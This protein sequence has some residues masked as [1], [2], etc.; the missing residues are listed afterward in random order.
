MAKSFQQAQYRWELRPILDLNPSYGMYINIPFCRSFCSFCPFYKTRYQKDTVDKYVDALLEEIRYQPLPGSPAWVYMGGGTPN[1]LNLKQLHSIVDG[2]SSRVDFSEAG[3]E[4]MPKLADDNYLEALKAMGFRKISMG[5]ESFNQSVNQRVRRTA[6]DQTRIQKLF[7]K[8]RSLG[9][10]TNLDL[11]VGLQSQDADIF[12]SDLKIAT[13]LQPDQVTIYPFMV[14]RGFQVEPGIPE[15]Q[16]FDLIEKA[17]DLLHPQGFRRLGPWTFSQA[18]GEYDCSKAELVSDYIGFG[19]GSFSTNKRWKVV[20]P[21]VDYYI[22]WM[23]VPGRKALI[24]EKSPE[25]DQWRQFGWMLSEMEVRNR[26][27]LSRAINLYIRWL[28]LTGYLRKGKLTR[29]GI[30]L[31][32]HLMKT[33][34]E[35]LPFPIQDTQKIL[36][37]DTYYQEIGKVEEWWKATAQTAS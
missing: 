25:A 17:W 26:S 1:T 30:L 31:S 5:V 34:V 33:I 36:N 20:N 18:D 9:L 11:M 2:I 14:V 19:A 8:A 28:R 12:L 15:R 21:P 24:A 4:L 29:K 10:F 22:N 16:Q 32:H 7:M 27:D 6:T 3:I 35:S 37:R 13:Q 23:N